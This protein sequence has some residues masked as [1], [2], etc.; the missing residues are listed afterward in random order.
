MQAAAID[1]ITLAWALMRRLAK[2]PLVV[3]YE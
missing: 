3:L 2:L 1:W